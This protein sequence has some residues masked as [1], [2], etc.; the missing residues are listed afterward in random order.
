MKALVF[1]GQLQ[2]SLAIVRSLGE[3][4]IAIYC[5]AE[6]KTGLALHSKYT[7]KSFVY[8][9]PLKSKSNFLNFVENF[10]KEN[11][12]AENPAII[13][14]QSDSTFLPLSESLE[15]LSPFVK[16][17]IPEKNAIDIAFD[18]SKVLKIA[19]DEG[20]PI[21]KTFFVPKNE[22]QDIVNKISFPVI[23]KP[24]SSAVWQN[25]HGVFDS[26]HVARNQFELQRKWQDLYDVFGDSPLIQEYIVGEE[27]G[28][29]FLCDHGEIKAEFAHKRIRSISPSG[30]ASCLRKSISMPKD[31][32]DFSVKLLQKIGWHGVAM[33][34]FKR[35]DRDTVPKLMEINGRF[36]GSLPLALFSGV[37]FPF[38]LY[39]MSE[40]KSIPIQSAY[41]IGIQSRHFLADCMHLINV[42]R[43]KG[44]LDGI[45]YPTRFETLKN[46]CRFFDRDLF[47]DVE[48]VNDP[49]PFFMEVIDT[50]YKNFWKK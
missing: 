19:E 23:V 38:L 50:L 21:P 15:R 30:G 31:M 14:A 13:Y 5:G 42:F 39:S 18:K 27:Y 8:P 1:D 47:Y 49:K 35:D 10:V 3:K 32:H 40:A 43:G 48:S 26:A 4:G 2:S 34:E 44:K 12:S 25:D 22:L 28:I 16:M 7:T 11:F 45:P 33:V 17:I 9:S 20:I 29:F 24:A 46:F 36:W 37:D 6:R 41:K